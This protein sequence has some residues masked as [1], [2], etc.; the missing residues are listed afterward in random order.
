M[1]FLPG[2]L[3]PAV[4]GPE[5]ID[6][7]KLVHAGG[8]FA[9][10]VLAVW[11]YPVANLGRLLALMGCVI[12]GAA[13]ELGQRLTPSRG[14]DLYDWLADAAGAVMGLV[15]LIGVDLVRSSAPSADR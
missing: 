6:L 14:C 8:Y 5:G 2:F 3:F 12:H 10:I 11:A 15:F 13:T 4:V 1:L 7:D 9:L